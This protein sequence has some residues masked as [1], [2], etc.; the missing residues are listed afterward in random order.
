[1]TDSTFPFKLPA[2]TKRG[3]PR[4]G[5]VRTVFG[6]TVAGAAF[7]ALAGMLLGVAGIIAGA[8]VG[9]VLGQKFARL[10]YPTSSDVYSRQQYWSRP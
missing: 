1:M 10:L 8:L 4:A 7:G 9:G 6:M 3:S 2:S 5:H